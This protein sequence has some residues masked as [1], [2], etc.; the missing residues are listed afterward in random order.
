M[1]DKIRRLE[2][3]ELFP[4]AIGGKSNCFCIFAP[5]SRG[6]FHLWLRIIYNGSHKTF[7]WDLNVHCTQIVELVSKIWIPWTTVNFRR[8]GWHTCRQDFDMLASA[9]IWRSAKFSPTLLATTSHHSRWGVTVS[10]HTVD[11]AGNLNPPMNFMKL[12]RIFISATSSKRCVAP[13]VRMAGHSNRRLWKVRL[14]HF[15]KLAEAELIALQTLQQK[16]I[17]CNVLS[18]PWATGTHTRDIYACGRQF[19]CVIL[20]N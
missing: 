10:Q 7:E 6:R 12:W 15:E 13:F 5:S 4:W 16:R 3:L 9:L 18:L 19:R 1:T 14:Y 11:A 2:S 8:Q 20:Q 17:T